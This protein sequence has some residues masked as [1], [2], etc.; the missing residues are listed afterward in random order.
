MELTFEN[1]ESLPPRK[2]LEFL[3]SE[4]FQNLEEKEKFVLASLKEAYP[5][6]KAYAIKLA[7]E[8]GLKE[9]DF[10]LQFLSDPNPVVRDS[11][12]KVIES[13]KKEIS[14][15]KILREEAERILS[16]G[17]KGEKINIIEKLKERKEKWVSDFLLNFLE[18]PSW[19][20]RNL[21]LRI[22]AQREDLDINS[23]LS[24]LRKPHWYVKSSVLE[25]MANKKIAVISQEVLDLKKDSNIEVKMKLIDFFSKIG[26]EEVIQHLTDLSRDPHA[27]VRKSAIKVLNELKRTFISIAL[28][29]E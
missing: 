17:G 5:P 4:E 13:H 6:L 10:F 18:D 11:A 23:L 15:D 21:T 9:E 16:E 25:L 24:L 26:G 20:V 8:M 28:S 7:G 14:E 19:E 1:F 2:K 27:W 22:L 3:K 12:V 29:K